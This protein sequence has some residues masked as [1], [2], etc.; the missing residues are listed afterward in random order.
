MLC[1]KKK[2]Q[3]SPCTVH[4]KSINIPCLVVRLTPAIQTKDFREK[5]SKK[6]IRFVNTSRDLGERKKLVYEAATVGCIL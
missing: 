2:R 3:M 1:V 5:F 6:K 4:E